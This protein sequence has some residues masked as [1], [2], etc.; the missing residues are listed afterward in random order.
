[1]KHVLYFT[2]EW[3]KPCEKVKPIVEQLNRD[4]ITARF[5]MIDADSE[6]EMVEDFSIKSIP[7][8]VL[9]EDNK[10]VGRINGAKTREELIT[11][12]EG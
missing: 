5:F 7:T 12:I 3:C 6:T 8:F 9:I 2:A 4:Q 1:V 10:E 11:F